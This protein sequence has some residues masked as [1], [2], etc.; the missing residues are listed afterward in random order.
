MCIDPNLGTESDLKELIDKASERGIKIILDGVF[1]HTGDDSKYFNKYGNYDSVGAYQSK[2]S[3]YYSWYTFGKFP[4]KYESWW[5]IDILPEVNEKNPA[6]NDFINGKDGVIEH[7]TDLG[8]GGWRLD[9]ADELP[10]EFLINLRKAVKGKNPNAIVIGEVWEDATN[11]ISYSERRSYFYGNQLD[12]I[13]NYVLKDSIIDYAKNGNLKRLSYAVKEQV[14]HYPTSALHSHMNLLATHDT[15]RLISSLGD[16]NVDGKS[17]FIMSKAHLSD[18][19]YDVAVKRLKI[20]TV[21]QYTLC[22]VPSIYY[23]DE[24]GMEGYSDPLCRKFFGTGKTSENLLEW[25]KLLGKIRAQLP[26]FVDGEFAE[27]YAKHGAY[28]FSRK[29]EDDIVF[30]GVNNGP[31]TIYIDFDGELFDLL[32][33]EKFTNRCELKTGEYRILYNGQLV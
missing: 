23:G 30:V 6:Y 24:L 28:V 13:M 17:R 21:L 16:L 20:A 4:N 32:T 14:D 8:I 26:V 1:S 33:G 15:Y 27:I 7:Y 31:S 9:V 3:P 19:Q 12:S 5:G 25:F 10:T 22:G 2:D 18:E 29:T 11:K